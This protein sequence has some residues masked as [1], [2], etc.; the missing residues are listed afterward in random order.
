MSKH[1]PA[2]AKT[3]PTGVIEYAVGFVLSLVL[4]LTAYAFV[5][6]NILEDWALVYVLVGLALT[7]A[8]VQLLFFLHLR[9]EAEPRWKLLTFDFMLVVVAILV[10]GSL[11]IMNNLD[12]NMMSPD[13]TNQYIMEDEGIHQ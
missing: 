2:T 11:W 12:Y 3:I 8:F 13:E 7:Q 4:T 9:Q 6:G 10:F 1:S 5:V